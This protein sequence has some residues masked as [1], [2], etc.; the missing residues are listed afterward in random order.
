MTAIHQRVRKL[1]TGVAMGYLEAG[2]ETGRPVVL[3]HGFTDS[4]FAWAP[5]MR[6]IASLDPSLRLFALH[7]RGALG[8]ALPDCDTC[9]Q[10]PS[11]CITNA[12][13]VEDV[14]AFLIEMDLG[15]TLLVGH[16][17]GSMVA[18]GVALA[19]PDLVD[20][21]VLVATP[22]PRPAGRIGLA[23]I[24]AFHPDDDIADSEPV[25]SFRAIA[26]TRGIVWPQGA[27]DLSPIDLDPFAVH[28]LLE[29]WVASTLADPAVLRET[30]ERTARVPLK[31]WGIDRTPVDGPAEHLEDLRVPTLAIWGVQDTLMTEE[32]QKDLC[33]ALDAASHRNSA[34]HYTWKQ[35]GSIA[36]SPGEPQ[37]DFGHELVAEAPNELARDIVSFL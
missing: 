29:G 25:K 28:R 17:M 4:G 20:K 18:R 10:Q 15:P 11:H 22:G 32:M 19:R 7:Q 16:S 33:A 37:T 27:F 21:L 9:R 36:C 31:Y 8:T 3:L 1:S 12:E 23:G 14:I 13:H 35:Y 6:Q 26:Q 24:T 30:A 34:M 2:P 5:V